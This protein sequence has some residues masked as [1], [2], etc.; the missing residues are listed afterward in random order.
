MKIPTPPAAPSYKPIAVAASLLCL[1]WVALPMAPVQSVTG[2]STAR[3]LTEADRAPD[4]SSVAELEQCSALLPT[5]AELI[6]DLGG[7]YEALGRLGDAESAYRRALKI[8][9]G[10]A[11][12]R[13]LLARLLERRGAKDEARRQIEAALRVQPNRVDLIEQLH[14]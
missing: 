10:F 1:Y 4:A 12:V 3:C 7:A 14:P 8:D 11:D 13:R 9:P 2:A 5:D 6:A